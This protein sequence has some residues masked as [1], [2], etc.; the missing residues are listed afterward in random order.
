MLEL[1]RRIGESIII[2]DNIT[3]TLRKSTEGEAVIG[4]AAPKEIA[5]D[6]KEV[7]NRKLSQKD[8]HKNSGQD[9]G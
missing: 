2:G 8:I 7:R 5:I 3:V 6:R 9:C 4:V 1:K